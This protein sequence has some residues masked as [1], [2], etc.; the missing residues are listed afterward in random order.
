M[1]AEA[2]AA[3]T[4]LVMALFARMDTLAMSL[5]VGVIGAAS[6]FLATGILLIKGSAPGFEVGQNLSALSPFLPG[7]SVSWSGALAGSIYG[8]VAGALAGFVIAVLWNLSHLITAGLVV[9]RGEWL[10]AE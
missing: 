10:E 6:I 8:F 7:Y 5:A 2:E 4:K 9:L 3:N 1:S